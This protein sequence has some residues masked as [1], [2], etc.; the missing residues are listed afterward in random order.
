MNQISAGQI[1]VFVMV[2]TEKNK[3]GNELE[4]RRHAFN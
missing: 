4:K 2:D 1:P 3:L